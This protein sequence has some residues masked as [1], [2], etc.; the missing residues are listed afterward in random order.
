MFTQKL[1]K[2]TLF[3]A[4]LFLGAWDLHGITKTYVSG[5]NGL[6]SVVDAD[7]NSF[8]YSF[9]PTSGEISAGNFESIVL[10]PDALKAYF[11]DSTN[12]GVWILDTTTDNVIAFVPLEDGISAS[13]PGQI[14]I[15][16]NG[17]KA[18]ISDSDSSVIWVLNT[19]DLSVSYISDGATKPYGLALDPTGSKLYA[20]EFSFS[21]DSIHIYQTIDDSPSNPSTID[22]L[23]AFFIDIN[24]QGIGYQPGTFLSESVLVFST[25]TD[26]ILS[27]ILNVGSSLRGLNF[28]NGGE[29]VYIA[30]TAAHT[31]VLL[32][33]NAI[34]E[35]IPLDSAPWNIFVNPLNNQQIYITLDNT[36]TIKV[37]FQN[38][39]IPSENFENNISSATYI[40]FIVPTSPAAP[41]NLEG[42]VLKNKFVMQTDIIHK[43]KW[44]RSLSPHVVSYNVYRNGQLIANIQAEQSLSYDDHN[45]S[46]KKTDC[47]EVK[48]VSSLGDEG[49]SATVYV[50]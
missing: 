12:L 36:E 50:P 32:K 46:S 34:S 4:L 19:Q 25:L 10:S 37:I 9:I 6:V 44:E 41:R 30:N 48:A 14:I 33:N 15:L 24:S 23:L 16:P 2:F 11:V 47:Y 20:S 49:S 42:S 22:G 29:D 38:A 35:L 31:I 28:A 3:L 39:Q 27:T 7:T 26:T 43:L 40:A 18:Y 5:Y 8:L 21:T 45:R 13:T 1:Q 17:L